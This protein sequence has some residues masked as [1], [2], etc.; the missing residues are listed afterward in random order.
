MSS[1]E[2]MERKRGGCLTAFLILA[3]VVNPLT[4][5]SYFVQGQTISRM[6]PNMPNWVIPVLGV[7]ALVNF[8]FV[9]AI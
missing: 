4:A 5:L 9:V 2:S 3:L 1:T 6:L 7:L 8:A